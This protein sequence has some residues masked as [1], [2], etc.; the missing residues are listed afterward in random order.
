MN[1]ISQ[2]HLHSGS[3]S[4]FL[5]S[6]SPSPTSIACSYAGVWAQFQPQQSVPSK[7]SS[8]EAFLASSPSLYG[9]WCAEFTPEN[10]RPIKGVVAVTP[11]VSRDVCVGTLFRNRIHWRPS[12]SAVF[13][14][15][16]S[17]WQC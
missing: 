11:V 9:L 1:R 3:S 15:R 4:E 2:V 10:A 5:S 13:P 6:M 7:G 14:T 8:V 12:G 17:P 16:K